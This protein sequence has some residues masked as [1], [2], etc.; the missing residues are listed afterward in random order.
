CAEIWCSDKLPKFHT[1]LLDS[2]TDKFLFLHWP[3]RQKR[4]LPCPKPLVIPPANLVGNVFA[5]HFIEDVELRRELHV[6][7]LFFSNRTSTPDGWC[8]ATTC[9]C[10]S[11]NYSISKKVRRSIFPVCTV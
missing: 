5:R 1:Q 9:H 6:E 10:C 2:F 7:G 3:S 11:S 8:C 4:T